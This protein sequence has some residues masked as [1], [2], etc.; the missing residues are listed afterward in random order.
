[1]TIAASP[2]RGKYDQ[3]VDR[4]SASEI[5]ERKAAEA[6]AVADQARQQENAPAE[7]GGLLG[8]VLG[9]VF[10]PGTTASGR[11]STRMST[12]EVVV[13]SVARSMASTAGRQIANAL[14]RGVLGGLTR[15]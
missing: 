14:L 1:M 2:L 15:R 3:A 13:K 7:E 12:T 9:S 5:L 11:R 4:E 6:Q 8:T 10:G